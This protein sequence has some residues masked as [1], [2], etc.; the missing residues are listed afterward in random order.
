M[1]DYL[2]GGRDAAL[3]RVSS[4]EPL[5]WRGGTLD[6]FDGV[7]WSDTTAPDEDDGEE[8]AA[9]IPTRYVE[10]RIEVLNARTELVFGGY[11]I[12]Q[13]DLAGARENSDGSW[14]VDEPWKTGP[15]TG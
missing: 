11:K 5:R 4:S 13:T 6:Y 7:R 8:V 14:S 9:G 15:S 1:G 10:Q 2:N 3:L 12:V